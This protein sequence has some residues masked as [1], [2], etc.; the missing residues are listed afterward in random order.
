MQSSWVINYYPTQ[1]SARHQIFEFVT[2]LIKQLNGDIKH[3]VA[4]TR[5]KMP[6]DPM[7]FAYDCSKL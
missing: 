6:D 1:A 7:S 2:D 3:L 4:M 5:T